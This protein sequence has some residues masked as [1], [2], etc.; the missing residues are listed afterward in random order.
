[1]G[2]KFITNCIVGKTI[3]QEDLKEEGFKG[4]FVGSGAGLP[5]FMNIPGEKL[6]VIMSC[7]EYLT[8]VNLMGAG[9]PESDTPV[10]M[11]KKVAVIGGGNTAI[12]AVRTARRLGAE[13]AVIVY[14]RSRSE[15]HT[16]EL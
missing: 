1:M 10:Y 3:S 12:D 2:V 4:I 7:N 13:R 5:N 16:S 14:R 9:D 15:E 8:R 6:I 11:G